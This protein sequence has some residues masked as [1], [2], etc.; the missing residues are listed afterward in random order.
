MKFN[1]DEIRRKL[2]SNVIP[3]SLAGV[4]LNEYRRRVMESLKYEIVP[5]SAPAVIRPDFVDRLMNQ[6]CAR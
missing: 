5:A 2:E 1:L 6:T 3:K 4:D